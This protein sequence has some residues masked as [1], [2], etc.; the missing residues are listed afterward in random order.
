MID[1]HPTLLMETGDPGLYSIDERAGALRSHAAQY[2]T[3]IFR[4]EHFYR[5]DLE[6]FAHPDLAPTVAD[7]LSTATSRELRENLVALAQHGDMESLSGLLCDIA[8]NQNE[9]RRIRTQANLALQAFGG[10]DLRDR[11]RRS[12]DEDIATAGEIDPEAASTWNGW[13]LT[14]LG[15]VAPG[16]SA[17]GDVA[18]YLEHLAREPKNLAS[19]SGYYASDLVAAAQAS[20]PGDWLGALLGLILDPTANQNDHLPAPLPARLML[21]QP[22]SNLVLDELST[23]ANAAPTEDFMTAIEL[24]CGLTHREGS[25]AFS[26]SVSEIADRLRAASDAKFALIRRRLHLVR[27]DRI[28]S[29]DALGPLKLSER[30]GQEGL[31]TTEDVMRALDEAETAETTDEIRTWY[32]IARGLIF[33]AGPL[34]H[35]KSVFKRLNR[36]ERRSHDPEIR[37]FAPKRPEA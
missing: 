26:K 13:L 35:R 33:E 37:R 14:G 32:A 4:G 36:F 29:Y 17:I 8:C 3:Q 5:D 25:F 21:L 15:F 7:L 28:W 11:V 31:W 2:E 10:Q 9:A 1:I 22:I 24:F 16:L 30:H 19:A 20:I 6:A 27:P 18:T 23:G 12:M 34:E